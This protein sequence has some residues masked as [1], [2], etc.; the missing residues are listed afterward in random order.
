MNRA[1]ASAMMLIM[2]LVVCTSVLALGGVTPGLAL[3]AFS[4]VALMGLLWAGRLLLGRAV[5]WKRSPMNWPVAAFL[6]YAM[7]RYF[8]SPLEYDARVEL[9]HV[10]A[11]ALVYFVASNQFHHRSDRTTLIWTLMAMSVFQAAYGLWQF[12]TNSDA[13]FM[14]VRPEGYRGRASGTY[15]CP[16][17]MA[18]FLE[19]TLAMILARVAV[20]RREASS[21]ERSVLV[22]IIMSFVAVMALFGIIF[23]FSR[24]GW[25]TTI[26]GLFLLAA[27]AGGKK[28]EGKRPGWLR[29]AAWAVI[30]ALLLGVAWS[31]EPVR[32]YVLRTLRMDRGGT[33]LALK[34]VSLGG[35]TFLWSGTLKIISDHPI[36]GSGAGSWQWQY[37][38]HR[39]PFVVAHS[40]FA[41]NDILNLTSDYG[42]A[43]LILI[44]LVL[45]RFYRHA[46]WLCRPEHPSE[47]RSF[48]VGAI[49]AVTILIIHSWFDFNMH[50]PANALLMAA[51]L[52]FTAALPD[53]KER[54]NR[55]LLT[56]SRRFGLAFLLLLFIGCGGWFY[57]RTALASI[58]TDLGQLAKAQLD[59]TAAL[60][61]FDRALDLD[62]K[63]PQPWLRVGDIQRNQ[64]QLR[65][66]PEKREERVALARQAVAAYTRALELNPYQTEALVGLGRAH[67]LAEEPEQALKH[68][69]RATEVSPSDPATHL[70]LGHFH[71][72]HGDP[73]RAEAAFRTVYSLQDNSSA[74]NNL[75]E[76]DALQ[77]RPQ[78]QEQR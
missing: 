29:F 17:H 19:I 7:A 66:G 16:N 30:V 60:D 3:P 2:A 6:A 57:S 49:I 32:N 59:Y 45:A 13:I 51:I 26:I 40:E 38:K 78:K 53:K 73:K 76:L 28:G 52:G 62:L 20:V 36:I 56:P 46:A 58:Y 18:G 70:A 11:C 35:R 69:T 31:L 39:H 33:K 4:L 23:S 63:S 75:L 37:Q 27:W 72:A 42:G 41:H 15:I 67:E 50:I 64:S 77:E 8:F 74:L 47:I 54:F 5:Y 22:K 71:R 55:I 21:L 43:G 9:F 61:Y 48:A 14:W 65:F 44:A 1:F 24:A 68:L 12:G 34:D 10:G 25:V